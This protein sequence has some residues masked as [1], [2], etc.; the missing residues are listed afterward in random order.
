MA[1]PISWEALQ[2]I[3]GLLQKIDGSTGWHTAIG[4]GVILTDRSRLKLEGNAPV[5]LVVAGEL[6]VSAAASSG[7]TTVSEMDLTIE[8]AVPFGSDNP[9]LMAH[10]ARADIVRALGVDLRGL[11]VRFNKLDITSSRFLSDADEAGTPFTL[12]QVTARAGLTET[13]APAL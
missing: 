6:G 9:E 5:T 13:H 10:R 2:A 7:R 4:Q 1:E 12:A 11:A 8:V 3:K